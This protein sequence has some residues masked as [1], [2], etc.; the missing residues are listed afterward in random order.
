MHHGGTVRE[1]ASSQHD[2]REDH[3]RPGHDGRH[4]VHS[5]DACDRE[6]GRRPTGGGRMIEQVLED[7]PYLGR[8]DVPA[9]LEYAA[10]AVSERELP[11]A[12]PA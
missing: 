11:L 4:T 5:R 2:V 6:C 3:R 9:A 1:L 7:Y 8:D 12:R 10:V